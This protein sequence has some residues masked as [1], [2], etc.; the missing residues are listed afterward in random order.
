MSESVRD[1]YD[2]YA[3]RQ[4]RHGINHRHMRIMDWLLQFGMGNT[5]QVLE[6]GCGVG[7]QT[8]LIAAAVQKGRIVA[9]DISPRSVDLAK[10]RLANAP[11]VE[12]LL[13]DIISLPVA[14]MFDV[15]VLPDVLEH[16]PM[17]S[18]GVL[19]GK[20]AQ[21]LAPDGCVVINIPSAQYLEWNHRHR[22]DLL[23]VIDQP[24]HLAAVAQHVGNAGLY[25]HHVQHYSLWTNGPD[26]AVLVAKH[27]RN[28][29]PFTP[30]HA[31]AGWALRLRRRIAK[32][33]GRAVDPGAA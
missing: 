10:K 5:S 18:H 7:T 19:F 9:N 23:Q 32:L 17:E 11:N 6:I 4:V 31:P 21:L 3:E 15:I 22:P 20:I 29:L 25:L 33:R 8:E 24:L 2:E 12:F 26:A 28:D 27:Y 30:V 13:G 14:G 16:I 1:F